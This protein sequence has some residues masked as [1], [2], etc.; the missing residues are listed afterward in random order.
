[1]DREIKNALIV[2]TS[3]GKEDHG[4][5]TCF[6]HLDYGGSGQGFGGYSFQCGKDNQVKGSAFGMD[7]IMEI[8]RVVG[9]PSWEKL[10]GMHIRVKA[11]HSKVHGIG[12]IIKDV[13]FHPQELSDLHK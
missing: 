8:L 3:L 9:A 10:P 2:S 1:M 12:H 13:W 7:F 6:L 11:E 4:I 5:M